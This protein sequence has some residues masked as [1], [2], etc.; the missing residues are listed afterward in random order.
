MRK[1][2]RDWNDRFSS[3]SK[4]LSEEFSSKA[5]PKVPEYR[6]MNGSRIKSTLSISLAPK[7]S[8]IGIKSS[9][10]SLPKRVG[11]GTHRNKNPLPSSHHFPEKN[12]SFH[13]SFLSPSTSSSSSS[14]SPS[15]QSFPRTS[16]L[17][18]ASLPLKSS[19]GSKQLLVP[20]LSLD[21]SPL[22]SSLSSLHNTKAH[23]SQ[24]PHQTS[25][26]ED[27]LEV[28][29]S[30]YNQKSVRTTPGTAASVTS[31]LRVSSIGK[32]SSATVFKS[33][34]L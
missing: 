13:S 29:Y 11:F 21:V 32:G 14:I 15:F 17:V 5:L 8:S 26:E 24:Q 19:K 18:N 9:G 22:T 3:D 27:Y 7:E 16:R 33:I 34:L 28:S 4:Q 23:N 31:L 1:T 25:N 30:E 6:G 12:S 10:K 2:S 20:V